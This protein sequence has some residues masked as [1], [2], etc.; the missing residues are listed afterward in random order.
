MRFFVNHE[1]S[2]FFKIAMVYIIFWCVEHSG[3]CWENFDANCQSHF[4]VW[5]CDVQD[6]FNFFLW[7]NHKRHKAYQKTLY[8]WRAIYLK[9][10]STLNLDMSG[11]RSLGVCNLK[12]SVSK[13]NR[14]R[15][16]IGPNYIFNVGE[17][18]KSN[19]VL[20]SL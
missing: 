12:N 16:L 5:I 13:L 9:S 18:A 6:Q 20:K 10:W 15:V 17:V 8:G 1:N 3:I 2:K 7:V 14:S 11:F 19:R 4:G